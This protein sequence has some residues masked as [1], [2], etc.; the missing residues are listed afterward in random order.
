[1]KENIKTFSS[2]WWLKYTGIPISNNTKE[3][4]KAFNLPGLTSEET[5]YFNYLLTKSFSQIKEDQWK[6]LGILNQK[7]LVSKI[8]GE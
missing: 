4:H 3:E 5:R 1:M 8:Q 7:M 6:E 2:D